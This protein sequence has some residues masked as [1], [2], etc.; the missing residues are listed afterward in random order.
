MSK[1]LSFRSRFDRAAALVMKREKV[2]AFHVGA[3]RIE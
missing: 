1:R 2:D 3:D